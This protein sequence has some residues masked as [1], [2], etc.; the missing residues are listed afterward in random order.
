[1]EIKQNL[2]DESKYGLK[3]PY[4]MTPKF[5]IVHNTYN[6]APAKN[7]ISY[8][9]KNDS[10]TSF[11]IAV[12]DV[13]AIQGIPFN[14][15]SWNCGDGR[16]G[17]GNRNGI[18]IEICYSKSGGEKWEKAKANAVELI[19]QLLKQYGWGIE[20]VK[21]HQDFANKYCPHR[22]LDEGWEGFLNLIRE[23]LGQTVTPT[24]V[25]KPTVQ[26]YTY[27]DFVGDVQRACGAKI[28]GIAGPETLS[29]TVTVSTT[30]NRK[31]AVVKP[32]QRYLNTL[33]FDCGA[34]DGIAGKLF[35][36]AVRSYQ[37]ANGC[38]CDGEIT[39]RNKTWKKLLKLA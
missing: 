30:K 9:V 2:L 17:N 14:R 33:G 10:S 31:H 29:K 32:L 8:M 37:R 5:I 24:V 26:T 11:H 23:K 22:I 18:S 6:D 20:Q 1:M 36:N 12:D 4:E 38:V 39:A 21:K 35:D 3:C 16:N 25:E 19:A 13:E 15:N 7:E 27:K 28:D 34:V